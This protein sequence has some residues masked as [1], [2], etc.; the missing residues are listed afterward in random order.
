MKTPNKDLIDY[1]DEKFEIGQ[2]IVVIMM[3]AIFVVFFTTV[4]INNRI[5]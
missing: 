1:L 5:M 4:L 2:T 3:V